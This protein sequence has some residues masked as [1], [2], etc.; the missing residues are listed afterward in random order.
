VDTEILA[1]GLRSVL[2]EAAG[3]MER[4]GGEPGR[5]LAAGLRA[6]SK[7]VPP[8]GVLVLKPAPM[9]PSTSQDLVKRLEAKLRLGT[10]M[11]N[12]CYNVAQQDGIR[13]DVRESMTSLHQQWDG[14]GGNLLPLLL[15]ELDAQRRRAD[16]AEERARLLAVAGA[17]LSAHVDLV[18][19]RHGWSPT[20]EQCQG[21]KMV[22][23]LGPNPL[24]YGERSVYACPCCPAYFEHA[25]MVDKRL[26]SHFPAKLPTLHGANEPAPGAPK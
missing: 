12:L 9:D 7:V 22:G 23:K 19:E 3:F 20:P 24:P 16:D 4:T 5:V 21:G 15:A 13:P 17:E 18:E 1:E 8:A 10:Q 11:A 25:V 2:D 6:V 26:P 14:L